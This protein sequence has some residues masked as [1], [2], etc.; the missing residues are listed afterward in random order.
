MKFKHCIQT[1]L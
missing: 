1:H